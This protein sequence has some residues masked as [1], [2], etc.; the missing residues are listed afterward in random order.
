[1]DLWKQKWKTSKIIS[2]PLEKGLSP[3]ELL[4]G[5]KL[6]THLPTIPPNYQKNNFDRRRAAKTLIE[7]PIGSNVFISDR[8]QENDE[9][10]RSYIVRTEDGNFHRNRSFLQPLRK[11]SNE[12]TNRI[13]I[14][15]DYTE[16][17]TVQEP[18]LP[19]CTDPEPY[20]T[21]EPTNTTG[22]TEGLRR[23]SRVPKLVQCLDL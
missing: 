13:P 15:G 20:Q 21:L 12:K 17:K 14:R 11:Q 3:A 22:S 4:M 7:L 9:A 10:P 19:A 1:M 6:R 8:Q 18:A 16:T 23:S 5:R 2:A